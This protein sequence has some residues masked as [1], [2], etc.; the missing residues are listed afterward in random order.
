MSIIAL[1]LLLCYTT[2]CAMLP[3][4]VTPS[5]HED[6]QHRLLIVLGSIA[7]ILAG[8]VTLF[9]IAGMIMKCVMCHQN[10]SSYEQIV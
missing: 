7:I 4:H 5:E 6:Q 3:P 1:I 9:L 10:Y 2:A 8:V